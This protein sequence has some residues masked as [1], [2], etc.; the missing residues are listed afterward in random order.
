LGEEVYERKEKNQKSYPEVIFRLKKN[1]RMNVRA[2]KRK[3]CSKGMG[4]TK[5]RRP[6][7]L[8]T[9]TAPKGCPRR[10]KNLPA[11]ARGE[12]EKRPLVSLRVGLHGSRWVCRCKEGE[13]EEGQGKEAGV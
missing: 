3:R 11:R 13:G 9:E 12:G 4:D 2:N 1:A 5:K 7:L 8:L 10:T 6:Q